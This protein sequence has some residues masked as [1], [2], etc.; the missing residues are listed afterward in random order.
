MCS[1]LCEAD[2]TG[3]LDFS[4]ISAMSRV[5]KSRGPD[6]SGMMGD[7]NVCFAHN[8]LAVMDPE[9]G[10][11][12][13]RI[14]RDG[15]YYSI[16]YN[17][18]IYNVP[19]LKEA[20]LQN[21][22]EMSTSC[23]TEAVLYSY[24]LYGESCP[25]HLNGIFA[26]IIYDESERK[27]F[28][29]RDRLGVKPFFY[30]E[31]GNT[32]I[33]ASEVKA[34]LADKRIKPELCREGIWQLLFMSPVTANG[35]GVFKN[36]KELLPGECGVYD[37][38]GLSLRKYWKL[39]AAPFTDDADTA[40]EKVR[41][42]LRDAVR[43]QLVSDV[44]VC[45]FLSGGL[46]SSA[47]S[48]IAAEYFR[49]KGETLSTYSF[50]YEGN[51]RE[52]KSSLFQPQ[53]DDEFAVAAAQHIGS[54]HTVLTAPTKAVAECLRYAVHARD[55]PGQADIDSSLLYFCKRIKQRHTVALSGECADEI[56]GGYPWFYR[57]EMLGR[58]FFP[59]IHDP[60]LR[61]SMFDP[62]FAHAEEGYEYT[63]SLYRDIKLSADCLE[64]DS[65]TMRTSRI[66]TVLSV[67][68]FMTSLLERKDRMSMYSALEVRVPFAD[69][70]IIEYVYNVPWE[71]KFEGGV[72]KALLRKAMK[73]YLPDMI[74]YRKK[75]PYPKT[76]A[77]E[78]ERIVTET[79]CR[80]LRSKS[81]LS[82][83][84]NEK[85]FKAMLLSEDETWFGQL[86]SKP[87]LIAWLLQLDYFLEDYKVM[88]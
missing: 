22:I 45:T 16:I 51:K 12:P 61:P 68:C 31:V 25:E 17:G 80:R 53:G 28:M 15:K 77:K 79:L 60:Y 48:A 20:L 69:H 47:V 36:I 34:L 75:S 2:F 67:D 63:S 9:G 42:L 11:Q 57:P 21:G 54:S 55:L 7:G 65:D 72:E 76:H 8:R 64:D 49:E 84:L 37:E 1:I 74:L 71:I 56:F 66:A 35:S 87:Q 24:I 73:G 5:M 23:D 10:H 86:M 46:D 83:I 3:A 30:T 14:C 70:R 88:L 4:S 18:E 62:D 59:W 43:R 81:P 33:C 52:F 39:R 58:D 29:A 41:F 40:A 6:D 50:E 19:E 44:P 82:D 38:N 78:Y 27:L 13:M 26:F 32:L 85:A